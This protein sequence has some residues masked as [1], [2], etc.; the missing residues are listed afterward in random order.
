MSLVVA[1]WTE[2]FIL[3]CVVITFGALAVGW[4]QQRQEDRSGQ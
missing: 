1:V 3:Y 4:L 2:P